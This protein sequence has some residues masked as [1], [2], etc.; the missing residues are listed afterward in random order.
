LFYNSL[1]LIDIKMKEI[2]KIIYKLTRYHIMEIPIT[3][4]EAINQIKTR[5][6]KKLLNLCYDDWTFDMVGKNV[7][8]KEIGKLGKKIKINNNTFSNIR[9]SISST[10][11][12]I[13]FSIVQTG[14]LILLSNTLI[15]DKTTKEGLKGGYLNEKNDDPN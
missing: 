2:I 14:G 15:L 3:F 13:S 4:T 7:T 11:K 9:D 12:F 1:N 5:D 6:V 8:S 10:G